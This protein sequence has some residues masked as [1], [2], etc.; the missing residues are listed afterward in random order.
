MDFRPDPN[1]SA[2]RQE[3][4]DFLAASL[5]PDLK[6]RK[7]GVRSAREK[8]IPLAAHPQCPRLG[9][10]ALGPGARRHRL[11]RAAAPGLR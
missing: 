9:R 8:L 10:A 7:D 3:V 11:E 4:R 5:P 6:G 1:L 2:F